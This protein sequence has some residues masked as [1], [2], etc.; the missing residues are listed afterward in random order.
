MNKL[1]H[2]EKERKDGRK[3]DRAA[4]P[5]EFQT[6]TTKTGVLG[7]GVSAATDTISLFC[8][9]NKKKRT[10]WGRSGKEQGENSSFVKRQTSRANLAK[11][12]A[13][14]RYQRGA[15]NPTVSISPLCL[16]VANS[17]VSFKR[18]SFHINH[19]ALG[20]SSPAMLPCDHMTH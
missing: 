5:T 4:V 6:S 16:A 19:Y 10:W 3:Q 12:L 20:S 7:G 14:D 18:C 15:I 1:N 17:P 11:T 13:L 8:K 9:S 2:L